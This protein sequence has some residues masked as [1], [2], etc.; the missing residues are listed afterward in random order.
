MEFVVKSPILGFEQIEKMTLEKVAQDDETFM[1]LKSAHNDGISFTLVNPYAVRTDYAFDIPTPI[2]ELL[3]LKGK[4]NADTNNNQL[5]VLNI[6]CL[7]EP[8]QDSTVNFLAPILFNFE[9]QT[10]A[11]VVLDSQNYTNFGLAEPI[12]K[13]FDFSQTQE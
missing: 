5:I 9:N 2:V 11:Q 6:V 3:S 12:S 8:I 13:F 10:M 7:Q 1:Q 4:S